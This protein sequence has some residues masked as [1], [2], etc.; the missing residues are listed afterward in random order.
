[1]VNSP[2]TEG[3]DRKPETVDR[4]YSLSLKC[5]ESKTIVQ[6][7]RNRVSSFEEVNS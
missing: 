4:D 2:E 5:C 3:G 1:M 7:L 6:L